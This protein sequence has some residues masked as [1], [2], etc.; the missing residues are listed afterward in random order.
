MH[1]LIL[2]RHGETERNKSSP[3]RELTSKGKNAIKQVAHELQTYTSSSVNIFC[4]NTVRTKQTAQLLKTVLR[5]ARIII[6]PFR[7]IGIDHLKKEITEAKNPYNA[8][9]HCIH[10]KARAVET[11]QELVKR[12][13]TQIATTNHETNIIVSHEISLEAFFYS[14]TQF[15]VK[16][17]SFLQFFNYGDYAVLQST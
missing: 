15:Q 6:G 9:M 7:I 11:P 16:Y 4:T 17:Q 1:T 2:I 12:W 8:Y 10:L 14:Q 3:L 13:L 5:N